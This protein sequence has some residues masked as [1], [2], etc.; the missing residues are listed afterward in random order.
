MRGDAFGVEYKDFDKNLAKK[1]LKFLK[2]YKKYVF[3]AF[4]FTILTS[5][6]APIR[7]YLI[8]IA[9][10]DYVAYGN[11]Q[12]LLKI[13]AII[14]FVIV[15]NATLQFAMTYIMQA[16]GQK[17]LLDIRKLIFQKL[18]SL[19]ISYFDKNPI[20]RIVTRLTNDVEGLN[21][22]FSQGVVL[23]FADIFLI[24]WIIIF[25][26]YTDVNLSLLTLSVLPLLFIS[27]AIFRKRV[28]ELFRKLRL[29]LAKMNSFISE[30]IAGI[31]TTKIF[32][33]ENTQLQ[34][35]EEINSKTK[36]LN[37][38]TIFYYAI[39]FPVV[40]LIMAFALAIILWST[41][42]NI[43]TGA[44]TIGTLIAFL[45]YTE[46]F[47]RPVRDL[48]EK[49]TTL[50]SAMASAERVIEILETNQSEFRN[51]QSKKFDFNDRIEFEN[52]S[53]SYDGEIYVLKN[54]SFTINK[55]EKVAIV[56]ATGSGK[57]TLIKLLLKFYENYSG[58]I[59]IDGIDIRQIDTKDLRNNIGLVLQDVFLF[60]RT[61]ADNISMGDQKYSSEQI[62]TAATHIGADK[63]IETLEN[64]YHT[65]VQE[66]GTNFS[67][68]QRQLIAFTRAFLRNPQILILDEATANIDTFSEEIIN[69]AIDKLLSNRTAIVIAHR[70]STIQNADK[71]VV[72]HKG[73]IKEIGNHQ[74]L[75]AKKGLYYKLYQLQFQK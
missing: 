72:L 62:K 37:I 56:G 24:F 71:I 41:A 2:P 20:G 19:P 68:G 34:K 16:V 69:K 30:N 27:T 26:F 23:I 49:Y 7:P 53:F 10:D 45:Q 47:F 66:L 40:E 9:I 1:L 13:I 67:L 8:K 44:I 17:T 63:F 54:I 22:F 25:M 12:G 35:F 61:I 75:L 38:K 14:L 28:R 36:D 31:F 58:N 5:S 29:E 4:L 57:S 52:V 60:S 21:Q 65:M 32:L 6:I 74:E 46:M 55:G 43:L 64:G 18:N 11:L 59:R 73:E 70:L 39:F 3:T 50:Q 48:S 15:I 42:G 51:N 33:Q